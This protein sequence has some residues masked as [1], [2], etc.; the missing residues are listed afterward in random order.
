A[1]TPL[2]ELRD[3]SKRFGDAPLV[4]DQVTLTAQ[5][6]EFITLIGPSG[7][8]KSTL[9]RLVAGLSPVTSGTVRIADR[10]P[11][12]ATAADL[13][14][15]FQDATLLPWRNV[16]QNVELPLKLRGV[17]AAAR[18]ATRHHVLELVGLAD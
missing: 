13:A 18:R 6:G 5:P 16:A 8:G 14:F 9:L 15:V 3:V 17:S 11:G 4:L 1:E 12:D 10:P 7:C 2:V